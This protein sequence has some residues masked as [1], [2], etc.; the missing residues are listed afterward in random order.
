MK[1][2]ELIINNENIEL[3]L[4]NDSLTRKPE[5]IRLIKLLNVLDKNYTISIDGR[6]GVGKTFF[7]KQ[8]LY[9]YEEECGINYFENIN[10][11][12]AI[13]DFKEKYIPVYYNAWENDDHENVLESLI[14]SILDVYPKYKKSALCKK[15]DLDKIVKP[16]LL[17]L[18]ERGTCGFITKE[19][20]ENVKSFEDLSKSVETKEEQKKGL[21][22]IFDLLARN[23]NRIL[24]IIDE[25]DRCKPDYA[26]KVLETIKHFY[27]Y[28][29]ITTLV[30]TNNMQLSESVKHFYGYNFDGYGY[31]NKMYD[32]VLSLE[33]HNIDNYLI[34]Y[35]K[36]ANTSYLSREMSY[37]LIKYMGFSLRECNSYV[38]MYNISIRYIGLTHRFY[39]NEY[40]PCSNVLLPIGLALKVKN[41]SEYN[42]YINGKSDDFLHSFYNYI[43]NSERANKFTSWFK[44]V[45]KIKEGRDI[46]T[47]I[48]RYYHKAISPSENQLD[49]YPLLEALSLMGNLISYD[50]DEINRSEN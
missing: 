49:Q 41:I 7:I 32:N 42:K 3:T 35:L 23:N 25:L 34:N 36:F 2:N 45:F 17:N 6:W 27:N 19:M 40:L 8:L 13:N 9:L 24:L 47:E 21:Y 50:D 12:N 14:Y 39:K 31:L 5:L 46:E 48:I 33:I 43:A 10:D 38:S 26:V 37:L 1:K 20:L 28:D 22:E 44:D 29:S 30:V 11:K 15:Q 4:K 16:F 18:I